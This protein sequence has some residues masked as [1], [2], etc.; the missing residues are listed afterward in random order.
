MQRRMTFL[1][2]KCRSLLSDENLGKISY[3]NI[4]ANPWRKFKML[5]YKASYEKTLFAEEIYHIFNLKE[6][7]K[8]KYFS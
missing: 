5:N 1:N 7:C 8:N 4:P 3:L 6:L 2:F